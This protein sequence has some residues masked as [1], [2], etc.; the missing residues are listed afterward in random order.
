MSETD[1]GAPVEIAAPRSKRTRWIVA[2]AI[3]A[4]VG[5]IAW[6]AF[7]VLGDDPSITDSPL[8]GKAAPVVVL[9]ALER[10]GEV[11]VSAPGKVLIINF[12][13]PWCVPCKGE[14]Q[15]FNRA[16]S[17]W[18]PD[19]VQ[20][21]GIAYQSDDADVSAF[22]DIVGRNIQTLRD[23]NGEASIEFGVSGVPET[24]FIDENG[25]VRARVAGPVNE[26]LLTTVVT[27]LLEGKSLD[28]IVG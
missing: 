18:S 9:S 3:A 28:G 27:R 17:Q 24:F 16:I 13:A 22:L 10:D 2:A 14:H 19:D 26:K 12:W 1:T 6:A 11:R 23:D 7:A 5:G 15:L 8:V 21:V 25:I 20:M 4:V